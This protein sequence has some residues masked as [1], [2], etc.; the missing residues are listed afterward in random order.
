MTRQALEES[1]QGLVD[2]LAAFSEEDVQRIEEML[3][4]A[5]T[6]VL[7]ERHLRHRDASSGVS[8][9]RAIR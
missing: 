4:R 1:L 5:L 6:H 8:H 9:L 7:I 2:G 3:E